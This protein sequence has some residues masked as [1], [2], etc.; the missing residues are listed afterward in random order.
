MTTC[1]A[2]VLAGGLGTRL[3]PLVS[4]RPKPMAEINGRPFLAYLLD[5]L[6][7]RGITRIILSV[8]Y[9]H[10]VIRDFFGKLYRGC[11]LVY[12]VE[13]TPLGTGGALCLALGLAR[14][15]ELFVVNGDTW[16]PVSLDLLS[17]TCIRQQADMVI[18]LHPVDDAS[19]YG[20]IQLA[21]D[22]RI[23]SFLEK[24]STT[25]PALINGG[26]YLMK[27]DIF[28]HEELPL[29]F[30]LE[31]GFLEKA[32]TRKRLF[33]VV[34]D[35]PFIDIGIPETY[36]KAARFLPPAPVKKKALF[37]DRDGTI[38]VEK[39]YV[40]RK[41]DFEFRDGILELA[42]SYYQQGY[43]IFVITN[44]AGIARGYY[45]AGDVEKLH[46]WM[47]EQFREYGIELTKIYYCPH[48][49]DLTGPCSCRK[50]APGMIL[51]AI[52]EY[53]VD[54]ESSVLFGDKIS[55]VEAGISARIGTNYLVRETGTITVKNV[56]LYK[57]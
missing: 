19:R 40:F 30:S 37:L 25:G 33:G 1:E 34:S 46:A 8:G 32:T 23:T 42:R 28:S 39:N 10:E 44:Q 24:N 36:S 3:R 4:D 43:L 27:S 7:S 35:A 11:E 17:D 56:T 16:F 9:R 15:A 52:R 57:G 38:N 12:A 2:I 54:P 50:P 49:P 55:D 45:T 26:V 13:D 41:E 48:H 14:S 29:K 21:P 51:D 18:A 6:I 31:T 20:T 22:G 5:D 47:E 53:D